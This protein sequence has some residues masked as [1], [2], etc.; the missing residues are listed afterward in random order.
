[1]LKKKRALFLYG[2]LLVFPIWVWLGFNNLGSLVLFVPDAHSAGETDDQ[3][4][5][6]AHEPTQG[7]SILLPKKRA[8][9]LSRVQM[10]GYA[11]YQ[12][13]C[14]ACHGAR[15]NGDGT[16]SKNLNPPPRK[17]NDASY[18]ANLSDAYLSGIIKE[19]GGSQ[20]LSPLMPPWG[21]VLSDEELSD[22]IAFLRILPDSQMVASAE[23]HQKSAG[24]G[25]DHHGGAESDDHNAAGTDDHHGEE[26]EDHK[27]DD[28]DDHHGEEADDH[29]ADDT[30]DHHAN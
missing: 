26:A 9:L 1:M 5:A 22:L 8:M 6:G 18:M 20:G 23:E 7:G 30:D 11:S 28:T 10:R 21:G 16:N 15:G 19:G 13:Y 17:H 14:A 12:Y 25:G 2:I 3:P 24:M 4:A 29:K 27:A